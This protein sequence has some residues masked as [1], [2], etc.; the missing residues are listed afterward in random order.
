MAQIL[1]TAT[2][3]DRADANAACAALGL[4][5]ETL[6]RPCSTDPDG[7]LD[8]TAAPT[9]YAGFLAAAAATELTA[10]ATQF[11]TPAAAA[12]G[13]SMRVFVDEVAPRDMLAAVALYPIEPIMSASG[14]PVAP[15]T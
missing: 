12:L 8:G 4:G 6:S 2:A 10:L 14:L 11:T 5:P 13:R 9:H 15:G 3:A 7:A 1:V